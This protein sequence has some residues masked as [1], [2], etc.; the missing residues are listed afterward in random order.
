MSLQSPKSDI[1]ES[2]R[3]TLEDEFENS[4]RLE[5]S[6]HQR[7]MEH[8]RKEFEERVKTQETAGK[9]IVFNEALKQGLEQK[10]KEIAELKSKAAESAMMKQ[11]MSASVLTLGPE[12]QDLQ[13]ENEELKAKL[14]QSMTALVS[15][16]KIAVSTDDRLTKGDSVMIVWNEQNENYQIYTEGKYLH[17]LHSDCLPEFGLSATDK[18]SK[19]YFTAQ[20]V[21]KE[22]CQSKKSE[23]RFKVA[24]GTKFYRVKCKPIAPHSAEL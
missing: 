1:I 5:R 11:S 10:D 20:V 18:G 3:S 12:V 16:G 8:L 9:Q 6:K 15:S 17:F 2:I 14:T 7:E 4:L 21:D 22:F 13:K 23:N 19:R 24:K